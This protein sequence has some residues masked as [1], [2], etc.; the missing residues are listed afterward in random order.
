VRADR[1]RPHSGL[2]GY[3]PEWRKV[4]AEVLRAAGIPESEWSLWSVDH[5]PRYNPA[6]EADHRKYELVAMLRGSH[7]SKTVRQ[8]GAFGRGP[9]AVWRHNLPKAGELFPEAVYLQR[10][11]L[12]CEDWGTA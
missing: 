10:R 2:R 4:R 8:D 9:A 3:V 11:P 12:R 1:E 5:R 6:I 7:S